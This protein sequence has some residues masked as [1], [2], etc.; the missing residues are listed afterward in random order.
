[1]IFQPHI[2]QFH[3]TNHTNS[4]SQIFK[5]KS[6]WFILFHYIGNESVS[7]SILTQTNPKEVLKFGSMYFLLIW[8]YGSS[9]DLK[10]D[11]DI[12]KK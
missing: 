7:T 8:E 9:M 11:L 10:N 6:H 4:F 1:M 3:N 2:S 12:L 5:Y